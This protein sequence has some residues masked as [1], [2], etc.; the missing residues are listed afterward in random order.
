M[1]K[2][3]KRTPK[4]YG[5]RFFGKSELPMY[6]EEFR[7]PYACSRQEICSEKAQEDP[8]IMVFADL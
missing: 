6:M 4:A 7:K 3:Y 1:V 5:K 8:K 2:G